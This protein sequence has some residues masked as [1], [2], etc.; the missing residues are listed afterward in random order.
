[1]P[2]AILTQHDPN[3]IHRDS[4]T[5]QRVPGASP[6]KLATGKATGSA[7]RELA[8]IWSQQNIVGREGWRTCSLTLALTITLN[9]SLNPNPSHNSNLSP[10]P[11]PTLNP[12][13][14]PYPY[15]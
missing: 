12:Y 5:T 14:Y 7:R 8:H 15:P 4:P 9:P 10:T 3:M 2:F 1:M 6:A 13:P 11:T